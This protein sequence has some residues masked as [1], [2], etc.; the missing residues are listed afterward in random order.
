MRK[1]LL[2]LSILLI[3]VLI[4]ACGS[5]EEKLKEAKNEQIF[6][7]NVIREEYYNIFYDNNLMQM[8][9]D[10]KRGNLYFMPKSKF[11]DIKT[12]ANNSFQK[13]GEL[14]KKA[15]GLKLETIKN[16]DN[17]INNDVKDYKKH[18]CESITYRMQGLS[19]IKDANYETRNS[20]VQ[21]NASDLI[22]INNNDSVLW[23]DEYRCK[24]LADSFYVTNTVPDPFMT[25]YYVYGFMKGELGA[26]LVGG[27]YNQLG[28]NYGEYTLTLEF[29]NLSNS[30][31]VIEIMPV[32]MIGHENQQKEAL[33]IDFDYMMQGYMSGDP[34]YK[35]FI[36]DDGK[37]YPGEKA[38]LCVSG[39]VPFTAD[40]SLYL[41]IKTGVKDD[42]NTMQL[43]L[44]WLFNG[45]YPATLDRIQI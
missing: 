5:S 16:D 3:A 7:L 20:I 11:D 37:L 23:Q 2:I 22:A 33:E 29:M 35:T 44:R 34:L 6:Q 36:D 38:R 40:Q 4:T 43:P 27:Q 30:K 10:I 13:L 1:F 8:S 24:G 32:V 14:Y 42:G 15:D 41:K 39:K 25:S 12:R 19:Y 21:T 18:L 17:I 9:R 45:G 31:N 26:A 28:G